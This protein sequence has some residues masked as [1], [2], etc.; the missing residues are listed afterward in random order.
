[1]H[2]SEPHH[3]VLAVLYVHIDKVNSAI[4]LG[5]P[6]TLARPWTAR[7]ETAA[8]KRINECMRLC[9]NFMLTMQRSLISTAHQMLMYFSALREIAKETEIF[10]KI[11]HAKQKNYTNTLQYNIL[12]LLT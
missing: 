5:A 8:D 4:Y 12:N 7:E 6:D 2:Y 10:K 9:L 11:V 3:L 1:V